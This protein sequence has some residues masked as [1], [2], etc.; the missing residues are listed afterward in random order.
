MKE[1]IRR[2]LTDAPTSKSV[3]LNPLPSYKNIEEEIIDNL[4]ESHENYNEN[5]SESVQ[6]LESYETD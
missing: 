2:K 6:Q 1:P 5:N 3:N 4:F